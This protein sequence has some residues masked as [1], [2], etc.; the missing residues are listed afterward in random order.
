MATDIAARGIDVS[1]VSHVINYD[2]PDTTDAYIHRIGRTGRAECTGE[3][4]TLVT[5]EDNFMVRAIDR[6]LG[7]RVERRTIENFDNGE[8]GRTVR[9]APIPISRPRPGRRPT[10]DRRAAARKY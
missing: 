8:N 7:S 4:F 3:A 9:S 2:V 10:P 6:V 5:A 1:K